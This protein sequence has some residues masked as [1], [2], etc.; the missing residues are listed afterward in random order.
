MP[1]PVNSFRSP[2]GRVPLLVLAITVAA[3]AAAQT[4]AAASADSPARAT[5]PTP[6]APASPAAQT[7]AAPPPFRL[8]RY[9]EDYSYLADP[10]R[11]TGALD[12]LKYIEL[13]QD[14]PATLS[15]GGE[16]RTRY[17]YSSAPA[18]GLRGPGH[19]DFVLQRFLLHADLH[20]G[21]RSGLHGRGFIQLLSGLV[22][23]E[24]FPKPGNQD[25]A[26]DVQQG[27]AEVLWGDNRAP[28]VASGEDSFGLRVG[29]QE[30]GLGSFR[31]VTVREPTNARLAFD[32]G[33]A[34]LNVDRMT[35]DAFLLRPVDPKIGLFNDGEDDNTTF[36]GVYSAVPLAPDRKLGIDG[37]YFG[38]NRE[39]ARFQSGTGDELRHSL[40][41]RIWGRD[42]NWDHD[43]EIVFQFGDFD[44]AGRTEDIL[45]WTI[46]S[47]TG[48]TFADA[49]WKPRIGL[50]L[51]VA[52]GDADPDDGRLGTFNPLFPRNNY[53]SD[54]N[55]LAPYN[56][57]DV[58]PTLTLRPTSDLTITAGWDVYFRYSTDDAVF[59]PTG[60]V[61]PADASD[62]RFV[63]SSLTVTADWSINRFISLGA[64]YVHFFR[65]DVVT[66]AGGKDVDFF[67]VWLTAK[68]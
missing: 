25:N 48:Y 66:D 8:F 38:L 43:T 33:R 18:F 50:K 29:R 22:S 26:L 15:L 36:W 68:F 12:G 17:E 6:A 14:P 3:P 53:F 35:F 59:S 2:R 16:A 51:N 52:S 19:D 7:P 45:A 11:R 10:T 46:A 23:G 31:L 65:G 21:D 4:P 20:I 58:H 49:G 56:F 61:I 42:N 9:E 13:A 63:G 67:G 44:V 40:G 30:I 60:I 5:D 39:N 41:A 54:A 34:T 1:N 47:N 37:Y 57:F 64:S 27:F 55:L 24:E 62:S 32:G 28:A